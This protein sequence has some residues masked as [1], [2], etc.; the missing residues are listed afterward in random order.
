MAAPAALG[1]RGSAL[2]TTRARG[3]R[4]C[5]MPLVNATDDDVERGGQ[6]RIA[7]AALK[8]LVLKDLKLNTA[9]V[10]ASS[11]RSPIHC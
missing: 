1:W 2:R 4:R 5:W 9:I 7:T 6:E 10:S 8:N 3:A 11:G